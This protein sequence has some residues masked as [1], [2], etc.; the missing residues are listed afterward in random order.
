MDTVG[1]QTLIKA[2]DENYHL[3]NQVI[4]S[5]I[6][7][8]NISR[9]IKLVNK[10][11]ETGNYNNFRSKREE[12]FLNYFSRDK[13]LAINLLNKYKEKNTLVYQAL[14]KIYDEDFN[15]K[16]EDI[17]LSINEQNNINALIKLINKKIDKNINDRKC[18]DLYT[19][20]NLEP[21]DDYP[22]ILY[23]ILKN[24]NLTVEEVIENSFLKEQIESLTSIEQLYIYLKLK[25]YQDSSLTKEIISKILNIEEQYLLDYEVMTKSD[26]FNKINKLIKPSK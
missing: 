1:Y 19:L 6:E 25:S 15:L 20:K 12:N 21:N 18:L 17:K 5:K 7:K 24:G 8:E 4:L 9:L 16:K 22:D 2:Y 14:M 10:R 11:L 3:K 13:K 23:N 26:N